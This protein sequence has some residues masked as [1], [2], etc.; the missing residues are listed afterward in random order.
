M[1]AISKPGSTVATNPE[2]LTKYEGLLAN[3]RG[4]GS[5]VVAYSGGVDSTFLAFAS[6]RALGDSAVAVTAESPSYSDK[7]RRDALRFGEQIGIRHVF[8]KTSE[9]ENEAYAVND[10]SRCYFCK[11]ELFLRLGEFRKE[12]PEYEFAIYGPVTDDLGDFRPGMEAAMLAGAR[13]PLVEADLSKAEVRVLS[14]HFGLE[15]WDKPAAPCLSSRVA[16]GE[17]ITAE[18]L[19]QIEQAEAF[20]RSE[21][22][23]EFRVRHHDNVA[24]LE[25][26]T[27]DF[28]RFFADGR[29]D[30]IVENLKSVGYTY[31]TLDAQGFRSGSMN[32]V[33]EMLPVIPA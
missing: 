28:E 5:A 17:Y 14:L 20:V 26:R 7:D 22:F 33:L 19:S 24:R 27:E 6:H 18:K 23:T 25:L 10:S 31:V 32:D 4:L 12:N 11:E 21:G 1:S 3:L 9:I 13:A 16:Y 2:L 8:V 15:S 30:R 29:R